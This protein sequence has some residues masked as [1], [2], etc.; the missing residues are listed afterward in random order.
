M[1]PRARRWLR[2]V[3]AG[4]LGIVLAACAV[5][6][7]ASPA[8]VVELERATQ[9]SDA[10][11][12]PGAEV[13]AADGPPD[14]IRLTM[15]QRPTGGYAVALADPEPAAVRDGIAEIRVHWRV[16]GA[17]EAVTQALTRP[18]VEIALPP[19]Y[20]G[21]RFVDQEGVVRAEVRVD[22]SQ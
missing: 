14:R 16:P 22:G 3:A 7:A 18:C 15:G 8:P 21:V 1:S 17:D 19:D 11:P 10:S 6:E 12:E 20:A 13:V 2:A 5:G 4:L 9:C